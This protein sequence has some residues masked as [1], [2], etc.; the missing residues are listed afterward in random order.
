MVAIKLHSRNW[1]LQD[2]NTALKNPSTN[3]SISSI[4]EHSFWYLNL[5]LML[6]V[7][8]CVQN[9]SIWKKFNL[10]YWRLMS[11]FDLIISW[12]WYFILEYYTWSNPYRYVTSTWAG[13]RLAATS[14]SSASTTSSPTWRPSTSATQP[15]Q[16]SGASQS[17]KTWR[18]WT[19]RT[20]VWVGAWRAWRIAR[21]WPRSSS[22]TTRSKSSTSSSPLAT[23][24]TWHT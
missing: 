15:S 8:S 22:R 12:Y 2:K 9:W 14:T 16:T 21:T 6:I 20:T 24:S 5:N 4:T 3:I 18:S 11:V 13:W 1:R 19:C 7:Q 10:K 23:S 17:W